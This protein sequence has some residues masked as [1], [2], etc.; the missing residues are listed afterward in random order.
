[1]TIA[2][3]ISD[4]RTLL[5]ADTAVAGL[6]DTR[7]FGGELPEAESAQMPRAAV[8]VSPAGGPGRPKFMKIRHTR[9]DTICYG[10]TLHDSWQL[11]L[12]VREAL[13][14]L[15]RPSGSVKAIEMSAEA[16]NARDP[17]KQWPTCYASYRVL[18]TIS[19]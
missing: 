8:V 5:L 2:D 15:A 17:V 7:V 9:V 18:S 14:T 1:M 3:P 10:A 11:H 13:E 4:I 16:A 19:V 12:A 6:V